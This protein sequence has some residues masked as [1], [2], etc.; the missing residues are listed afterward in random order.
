MM[1]WTEAEQEVD[2]WLGNTHLVQ[3]EAN[4]PIHQSDRTGRFLMASV[5]PPSRAS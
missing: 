2:V 3:V 5:N 1:A 4:H